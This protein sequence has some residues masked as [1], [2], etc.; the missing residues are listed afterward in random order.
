MVRRP[1]VGTEGVDDQAAWLDDNT[2]LY[3]KPR[4]GAAAAID[5]TQ[6]VSADGS[7]G[8]RLLIASA[9]SATVVR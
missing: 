9:W 8:P 1:L 6:A 7:A 2:V 3:G 5:D 4:A